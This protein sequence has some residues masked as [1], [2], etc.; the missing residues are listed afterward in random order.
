MRLIVLGFCL[1]LAMASGAVAQTAA[2][3]LNHLHDSLNL[4]A[5]QDAAW[6]EYTAAIA[7]DPQATA[8]RSATA[9]LLPKL[10]TPRR[11]A[12][13][14]ATMAEDIADFH[15]QGEAVTTFY[16]RLSPDQQR[17]FD[18]ETLPPAGSDQSQP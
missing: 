5:A 2:E 15:R 8:R 6:R 18:Q 1:C 12:L 9:Q 10:P 17:I 14:D 7:P 16:G 4:S 13:I 11:I 3:R